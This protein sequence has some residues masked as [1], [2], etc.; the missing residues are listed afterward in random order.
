[1]AEAMA[2]GKPV[3]GTDYSG[4]TDFLSDRTGFPVAF[5][6][7]ALQPG[8]YI[9]W[10]GQS[11]AEP[12]QAAAAK[13]MQDVFYDRDERQRRAAAG[14][15]LVEARYGRE[16]VG[17]IAAQRLREVLA[18]GGTPNRVRTPGARSRA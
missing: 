10:E 8:E 6:L 18:K 3:I 4:S 7:R 17:Q 11:W 2:T 14:K 13:A 15:A 12:D 1:M 5:T 16:N 9:F